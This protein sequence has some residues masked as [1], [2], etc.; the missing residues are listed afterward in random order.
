MVYEDFARAYVTEVAAAVRRML[1]GGAQAVELLTKATGGGGRVRAFGNGGSS[2]IVRSA[3][4]QLHQHAGQAVDDS[5][6]SP[7]ALAY[8]AQRHGYGTV[9]ARSLGRDLDRTG[10]VVVASVS[11]RSESVREAVRLCGA[12]RP[13]VPVLA[14]VGGDGTQMALVDGM[15]W[16]TGTTD[17]QVSEDAMLAVL[18]L[19]AATVPDPH[20]VPLPTRWGRYLDTLHAV[21]TVLLAGFLEEAT[22]AVADA[23]R[24][25]RHIYVLCPDG[26]PLALAGE[27]FAHNLNWD[28]PLGVEGVRPPVV[29]GDP[30]LADMSAIYNDHPDPA[31]GVRHQLGSASPHDVV[32]LLSYDRDSRTTREAVSAATAAG[33]RLFLLHPHGPAR[34]AAGPDRR[35]ARLVL[36]SAGHFTLAALVQSVAHLVCRTTRAALAAQPSRPAATGLSPDDLMAQDLAPLRELSTTPNSLRTKGPTMPAR[37]IHT[38]FLRPARGEIAALSR[39]PVA[40]IVDALG[41]TGALSHCLRLQTPG[42]ILCGSAVTALGPDVTVRRAAIDLAQPGDI[43]VVAAGGGKERSCFGGVTAAHMHSRG[44]T[45]V[46]VDGMVRDTAELRRIAFPT[47]ARGTTPLNYDYP[48]GRQE[49]AVNVPVDIDGVLISP[50]DVVVGDEDG[51]V[52]V[53]RDQVAAVIATTQAALTAE[54]AK[55]WSRRGK[56]LGA[57]QQLT[58]SGYTII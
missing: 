55:W 14:L 17:Q 42:L 36:P 19:A 9:F 45:G 56:S 5:M 16:A 35:L 13:P 41:K 39:L 26:G 38:E 47:V 25:R 43:V 18:T 4:L 24:G 52:V 20:E 11:G 23:I 7:A 50:G 12:G 1:T 33:T 28:A 57:V 30:S 49:G 53:P 27:H 22:E 32:F 48:A 34:P 6:M 8:G 54:A 58:E 15:V 31:H 21:D 37:E 51:T 3:L 29:I 44:I 46:L 40:S 10:L 2:A